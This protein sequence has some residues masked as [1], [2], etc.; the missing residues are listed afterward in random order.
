M[1]WLTESANNA[2]S[3]GISYVDVALTCDTAAQESGGIIA[4]T[5]V[6]SDAFYAV[7]GRALLHSVALID[8]DDNGA[9]LTVFFFDANV[10]LG[11]ENSPPSISDVNAASYLCH[12]DFST[13]DYKDLGGVKVAVLSGLNHIVKAASGTKDIYVAVL[14][15]SGTPTYTASGLRLRLGLFPS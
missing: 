4:D 1:T 10:S 12:V 13:G 3:E 5:Q 2:A 11:T 6:V 8:K 15:G 9:A 7:G 14:N